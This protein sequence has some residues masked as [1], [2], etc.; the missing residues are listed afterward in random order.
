MEQI[1]DEMMSLI[2]IEPVEISSS[3]FLINCT[4]ASICKLAQFQSNHR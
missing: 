4:L 1:S 2:N 3:V